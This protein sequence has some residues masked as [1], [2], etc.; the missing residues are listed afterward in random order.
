MNRVH[1]CPRARRGHS[2]V[3]PAPV[4]Q[5]PETPGAIGTENPRDSS[6]GSRDPLSKAACV[7]SGG[8]SGAPS[9][10]SSRNHHSL[11]PLSCRRASFVSAKGWPRLRGRGDVLGGVLRAVPGGRRGLVAD[12]G[13]LDNADVVRR[14][15]LRSLLPRLRARSRMIR[16]G[17][18][19]VGACIESAQGSSIARKAVG[20]G[21]TG[22]RDPSSG[23]VSVSRASDTGASP[24]CSRR[25]W[26]VWI[27]PTSCVVLHARNLAWLQVRYHVRF[28]HSSL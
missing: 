3:R 16:V 23:V 28:Q 22:P 26:I 2:R 12:I 21:V 5:R 25:F 6:V 14:H 17:G 20:G 15:A 27:V 11:R 9:L 4:D 7:P 8:E 19:G 1:V 24:G 18:G 10:R 13:L